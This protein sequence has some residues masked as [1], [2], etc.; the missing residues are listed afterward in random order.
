M[1]IISNK[2]APTDKN[3]YRLLIFRKMR[4]W[5]TIK[6]RILFFFRLIAVYMVTMPFHRSVREILD[7]SSKIYSQHISAMLHSRKGDSDNLL[8]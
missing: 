4:D 7:K 8:T 2:H 6:R 1:V 3:N 5:I